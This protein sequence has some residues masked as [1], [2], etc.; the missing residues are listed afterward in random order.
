MDFDVFVSFELKMLF[1]LPVWHTLR[2]FFTAFFFVHVNFIERQKHIIVATHEGCWIFL[3]CNCSYNSGWLRNREHIK[4]SSSATTWWLPND[5]FAYCILIQ[6]VWCVWNHLLH[7]EMKVI[8]FRFQCRTWNVSMN[9]EKC[10]K[11]FVILFDA[12]MRTYIS[13]KSEIICITVQ[14]LLQFHKYVRRINQFNLSIHIYSLEKVEK[15][16][17]SWIWVNFVFF[18]VRLY[19]ISIQVLP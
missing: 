17:P 11:F 6:H 19:P 8:K 15:K 2:K 7:F 10:R 5:C 18:F 12:P 3:R 9:E 14:T 1:F 4:T 16:V 13:S